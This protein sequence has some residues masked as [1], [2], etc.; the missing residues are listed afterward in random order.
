V[1]SRRVSKIPAIPG[2]V[3]WTGVRVGPP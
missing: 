3:H 1:K 2:Q